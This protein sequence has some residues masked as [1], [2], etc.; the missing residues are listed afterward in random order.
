MTIPPPC[1]L[2]LHILFSVGLL[3]PLFLPQDTV[4]ALSDFLGF[5]YFLFQCKILGGVVV[6][7]NAYHLAAGADGF[8]H[9]GN[10]LVK[11]TPVN[12]AVLYQIGV[13]DIVL[14]DFLISPYCVHVGVSVS[15][16]FLRLCHFLSGKGGKDRNGM[17]I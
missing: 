2:S 1:L 10:N 17:V 8:K 15:F 7:S 11:H 3:S 9:E 13:L 6:P 14:Y 16:P 12:V 5:F 4:N